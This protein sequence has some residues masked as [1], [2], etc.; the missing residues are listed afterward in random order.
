MRHRTVQGKRLAQLRSMLGNPQFSFQHIGE[1]LDVT[2]QCI[3]RLAKGLGINGRQREHERTLSR[4]IETKYPP[5]VQA[6]LKQIQRVGIS[7]LPYNTFEPG[8]GK[9][10]RSQRM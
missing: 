7:V 3:S 8:H 2:K 4:V 5:G 10:R 1:K 9:L 6:V